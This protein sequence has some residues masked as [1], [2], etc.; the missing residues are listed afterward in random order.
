MAMII[1]KFLKK[2]LTSVSIDKSIEISSLEISSKS[3]KKNSLFFA[4]KGHLDNGEKYIEDAFLNGAVICLKQSK[5]QNI[6]LEYLNSKPILSVPNL[7]NELGEIASYF[8]QTN[9]ALAKNIIATT[10]TNGKT[11]VSYFCAQISGFLAQKCAFLGTIGTGFIENL[12]ESSHTTK[13]PIT[14]QKQISSLLNQGAIN[15]A[16]EASSH[17]LCQNRLQNIPVNCAIFT[18]FGSDHLDYHKSEE[19]YF[20]AKKKLFSFKT[21]KKIVLNLDDKASKVLLNTLD[22]NKKIIFVAKKKQTIKQ[23]DTNKEF[24][25]FDDFH[26]SSFGICA[27]IYYK[28]LKANLSAPLYGK[29]NLYNLLCAVA[30]FVNTTNFHELIRSLNQIKPPPGRMQII[31]DKQKNITFIVD[32]AHCES[33]LENVLESIT[34]NKQGKIFC[35]FGAGGQRQKTKRPKMAK[36]V[37]KYADFAIITNDNPRFDEPKTIAKEIE[38][39]FDQNMKYSLILDRKKAIEQAYKLTK[40]K[41]IILVAGK[42]AEQYQMIKG[43]KYPFC[44]IKEIN[45]ILGK[46]NAKTKP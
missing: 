1:D 32:F 14:L 31:K 13:D 28:N 22:K 10:G 33:S 21:I 42:G 3:V 40:S 30:P 8:Y 18:N 36:I 9:F 2:Y 15:L 29:F 35:V 20:L 16:L 5:N 44:D 17:A 4:L 41:D 19:E 39:G 24:L 7:K 38:Q 23:T 45:K 46:N 12:K 11:S 27:T 37:Q 25:F 26:A 34:K 6:K 43:Q